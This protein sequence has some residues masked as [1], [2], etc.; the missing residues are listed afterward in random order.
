MTECRNTTDPTREDMLAA[1]ASEYSRDE[2]DDW[3]TES[4]I[5]WFAS[6]WHS[7][8]W[9]NLYSALS[10]SQYHPGPLETGLDEDSMAQLCYD[11]LL[12]T[13]GIPVRP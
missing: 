6:D 13:F 8:Q 11:T 10:T 2:R 7:G 1:I 5:Y 3:D 12:E 4:A 9:S